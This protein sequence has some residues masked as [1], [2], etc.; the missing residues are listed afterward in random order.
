MAIVVDL[1]NLKM[2]IRKDIRD[3]QDQMSRH[4]VVGYQAPYAMYVHEKVEMKLWGQF[5]PRRPG[6]LRRTR[7]WSPLGRAQAKFLE[8][9][10]REMRHEM[11]NIVRAELKRG[12][13]INQSMLKAGRALRDRSKRLVP[14]D[15]GRLKR[16][17][18]AKLVDRY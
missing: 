15:T 17:A 11:A 16:S 12:K 2:R 3:M 6:Q 4:V 9:P 14:V 13:T 5:R 7:F 1:N 10:A 18:F 8:Q